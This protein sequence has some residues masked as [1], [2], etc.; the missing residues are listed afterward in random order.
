MDGTTAVPTGAHW[1]IYDV[2][3]ADGR[4]VG[5]RPW[6]ED[7]DPAPLNAA[8]PELVD[9]P[10][11]IARP[12]VRAGYHNAGPR[13][14]TAGRGAEPFV[15]VSWERALDLVAGELQRVKRAHGNEAIYA[16]S[17]GWA[18]SGKIHHP[19]TLV[20]RL[21]NLCGGATDHVGNYSCGAALVVVPHILG[22]AAP[23]GIQATE[24]RN[25]AAHTGLVV[26]FGG[27]A[28][29]NLQIAFGGPGPHRARGWI[30]RL[31]EA[32]IEAVS[33]SPLRDDT[34]AALGARWMPVRPNSDTALMLGLAHTL[35]AEDLHDRAFLE[36]Y[37]VGF[38]RFR[39]YL[40]GTSDGVAKDADWA[41]ARSD[42]AADDI[43]ALAR[44]MAASRT[45][46]TL[47]YSL[48][49]A[50]RG[51]QPIWMG[52]TLAAM[53]GQI[54]LPGGGF[55]IGYGAM[56]SIGSEKIAAG[57]RG[58]PVGKDPTGSF[59]PVARIADMLLDPGGEYAFNGKQRI[60]PDIRMV[61]W[62]GG[63]PFHHHQDLNRLLR[64]WRK[65][66]TIVVQ[67][68]F[69]TP[70]ARHA[71]IVLPAATALERNDIGAGTRDS[72]IYA[73]RRAVEPVG[74]ARSD[75]D[76]VTA[77]AE[78]LGL[79]EEFTGGKDELGWIREAYDGFAAR[80]A[81]E[82]AGLP[83]F[84]EFWRD[85]RVRVQEPADDFVLFADFRADP[86]ASPLRTPS[87]RIEI[88][89]ETVAGFGY[90]DC[91]GHPVWIEPREWLGAP[92][93]ARFPLHLVSNQPATRLHSQ[94]DP[95]SVSAS[96]KV[97]GREA[98]T[99]HPDDAGPRGIADGDV[100]RIHNDRGQCLAGARVSE[101]VRPGVVVLPT[102]AWYDPAEPGAI[103]TLDRHGNPNLLTH[104]RGTSRLA[105][106][107]AAHSALVEI[108]R[109]DGPAPPVAVHTP[110]PVAEAG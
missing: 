29:K 99:I 45:M 57:P 73:M 64:A 62:A 71:D 41:A 34:V 74:G 84:E 59:I 96:G 33:I 13:S 79:A 86:E 25:I 53:L 98:A 75:Y 36:R 43:R 110:P 56:G 38:E 37:C 63:N 40:D 8:L 15:P 44:R 10:T 48:Q 69:W 92:L 77:L 101:A 91:P 61:W 103:G 81:R 20:R 3:V 49:R 66:E 78:R 87:G 24:W 68:P 106:A 47:S 46:I 16:G 35:V 109:W 42:I 18:S 1:G 83:P 52:I 39:A 4:V 72:T 70:A 7:P 105:Q 12:M 27:M 89:S 97:A 88:F 55:G 108:E 95:S 65:P 104:D 60:Y 85:G 32:G 2:L 23:V 50:D 58:L 21:L 9:H 28:P 22:T 26:S 82:G 6:E 102:G 67:D 76:I 80:M 51:E 94:L 54:G 90:D 17:Y 19:R 100:V 5:A 14:D 30:E 31:G 11:R 93:A 107:T